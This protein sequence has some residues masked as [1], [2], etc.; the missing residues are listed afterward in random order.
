MLADRAGHRRFAAVFATGFVPARSG[1]GS[2]A[3]PG[4]PAVP[5]RSHRRSR[6][7]A[8]CASATSSGKASVLVRDGTPERP[9]RERGEDLAFAPRL[10][11]AV[12]MAAGEDRLQARAAGPVVWSYGPSASTK[13]THT[14]LAG[15]RLRCQRS[16]AVFAA[17]RSAPA[18]HPPGSR[19]NRI[20]SCGG[21]LGRFDG[22]GPP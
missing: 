10:M 14:R 21:G 1:T 22:F 13:W 2:R 9:P 19:M 4:W 18:W 3:R 11:L 8:A 15:T 6:A 16:S 17:P 20:G 7:A 12:D 5:R